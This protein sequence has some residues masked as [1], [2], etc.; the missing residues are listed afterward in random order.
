MHASDTSLLCTILSTALRLMLTLNILW[1]L[2]SEIIKYKWLS[3]K[4]TPTHLGT[5]CT[6]AAAVVQCRPVWSTVE[7]AV[8]CP[9]RTTSTG[10]GRRPWS[11][12]VVQRHT[13][14][15]GC[16]TGPWTQCQPGQSAQQCQSMSPSYKHSNYMENEKLKTKLSLYIDSRHNDHNIIY[17]RQLNRV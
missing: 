4:N 13:L 8:S 17:Q 16:C 10:P 2:R 3:E 14:E 9:P 6:S 15:P 5:T 12:P 11:S 1:V 7:T